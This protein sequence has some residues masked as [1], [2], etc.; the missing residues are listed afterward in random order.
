MNEPVNEN[1]Y[2]LT[3]IE[4]EDIKDNIRIGLK[5]IF[6]SEKI[7]I[8]NETNSLLSLLENEF[9]LNYFIDIF[10]INRYSEEIKIISDD[11]FQ[12]LLEIISKTLLKFTASEKEMINAIRLIKTCSYFK[13]LVN[14]NTYFLNEKIFEIITINYKLFTY[15]LFWELWIEN[16]LDENEIKILNEIKKMNDDK[17]NYHYF[18]K[19]LEEN[20][21]FKEKYK[22]E[23]ENV[24]KKM[25]MI[26]LNKSFIITV[27]ESLSDKYL[28]DDEFKIQQVS[29]IMN[30]NKI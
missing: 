11:S 26:K 18:D 15:I 22:K 23:M 16:E 3:D 27:I 1:E 8:V 17:D 9:G 4:R 6:K 10:E 28:S 2:G 21:K 25:E 30:K 5:H 14:K 20:A 29:E 12:I 19:D 13:T 24:R 7:N